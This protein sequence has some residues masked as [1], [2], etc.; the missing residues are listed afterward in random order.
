MGTKVESYRADDGT[1]FATEREMVMHEIG[2]TLRKEFPALKIQ[3]GA[4]VHS[5]DRLLEILLPL[6]GCPPKN[7]PQSEA[8][9]TLEPPVAVDHG[10]LAGTCDCSAAMNGASDHHPSCPSYSPVTLLPSNQ[11]RWN[12]C[13]RRAVHG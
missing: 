8:Q 10:E 11:P 2:V 13:E 9:T 1:L 3:L 5:A 7:H 4:I 6:A 12:S